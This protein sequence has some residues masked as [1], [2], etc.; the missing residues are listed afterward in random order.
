MKAWQMPES[1]GNRQAFE[2]DPFQVNKGGDWAREKHEVAGLTKGQA[3][4]PETSADA[5]LKWMHYKGRIGTDPDNLGKRVPYQ[6]HYVALKNYNAAP[7]SPG[8]PK[9][10]DYANDVLNRAWAS[11]GDWQK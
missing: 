2:S 10:A 4:T 9:G 8:I 6:G 3:M 7:T 1:G 5:A 11:Y